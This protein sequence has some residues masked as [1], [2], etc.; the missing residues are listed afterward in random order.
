[1]YINK[2]LNIYKLISDL[3]TQENSSFHLKEN[4]IL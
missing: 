2:T 1:M 3:E 4:I